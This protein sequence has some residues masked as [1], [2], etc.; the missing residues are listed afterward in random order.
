MYVSRSIV[1]SAG[2][3][4]GSLEVA[5]RDVGSI[6]GCADSASASDVAACCGGVD[7]VSGCI[8]G[9]GVSGCSISCIVSSSHSTSSS[10][11]TASSYISSLVG[12]CGGWSS[13]IS[14]LV[15]VGGWCDVG[16]SSGWGSD[17]A[18][19]VGWSGH[20][21][22]SSGVDD[23]AA[24]CNIGSSCNS[25]S[26]YSSTLLH[27]DVLNS[28]LDGS[29]DIV[30]ALRIVHNLGLNWD[31]LDSFVGSFDWF[32]NENSF[33]DFTSN[34]LDLSLNSIIVS[35]GLLNG[36]SLTSDDFL[37]L[38]DLDLIGH[39][40]DLF[41]LFVLNIFLLE[42]N[43]LNSALNWDFRGDSLLSCNYSASSDILSSSGSNVLVGGVLAAS[44]SDIFLAS[45][46]S[47]GSSDI[48]RTCGSGVLV[49]GGRLLGIVSSGS[50][51]C[52]DVA[53]GGSSDRSVGG[54]C[55]GV[56]CGNSG[57]GCVV[58]GVNYLFGTGDLGHDI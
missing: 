35:D 57:V 24:S 20:V 8:F 51:A 38:N 37:I 41:D 9:C 12:S 10:N 45:C 53:G 15:G 36:D 54:G 6:V 17:V 19:G 16:S 44:S 4:A 27:S 29:G 34:V 22:G 30:I 46:G 43:V 14:G 56:T 42:G 55:G 21:V 25:A 31:V 7:G 1:G 26:L 3:V 33:L 58:G 23:I 49:G 48:L 47:G 39:L 18:G 52:D 11:S 40:V 28:L 2:L 32:L 5:A 50:W 13:D